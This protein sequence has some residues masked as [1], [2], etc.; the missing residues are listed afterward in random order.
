MFRMGAEQWA[1]QQQEMSQWVHYHYPVV[2]IDGFHCWQLP[3]S[4]TPIHRVNTKKPNHIPDRPLPP[5]YI[6]Y[7]CGEKGM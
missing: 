3:N 2:R 4:A 7:R 5:G 1:E 6:C